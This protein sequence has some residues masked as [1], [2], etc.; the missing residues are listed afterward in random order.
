[1]QV[2]FFYIFVILKIFMKYISLHKLLKFSNASAIREDRRGL[3]TI[4]AVK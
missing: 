1:M 2:F 4:Y 3:N